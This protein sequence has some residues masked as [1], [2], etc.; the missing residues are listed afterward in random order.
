LHQRTH[1]SNKTASDFGLHA[2]GLNVN[3]GPEPE[4]RSL[5]PTGGDNP[6]S[7]LLELATRCPMENQKPNPV[8]G[9]SAKEKPEGSRDPVS[10]D[11]KRRANQAT[12]EPELDGK[13]DSGVEPEIHGHELPG[14]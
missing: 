3:T 10:P 11:A 9:D 1:D 7:V 2:P 4:A 14:E 12:G 8:S 6:A 13:N 5:K